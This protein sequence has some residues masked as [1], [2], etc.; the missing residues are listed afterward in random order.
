MSRG[1]LL[2]RRVRRKAAWWHTTMPDV[3]HGVPS[4]LG[5]CTGPYS[6]TPDPPQCQSLCDERCRLRS[7]APAEAIAAS[8]GTLSAQDGFAQ[9]SPD[10]RPRTMFANLT[11]RERKY[12][13]VPATELSAAPWGNRGQGPDGGSGG[14]STAVVR[15]AQMLAHAAHALLRPQT[16]STDPRHQRPARS[17]A[18]WT[19]TAATLRH[20]ARLPARLGRAKL[21]CLAVRLRAG[22]RLAPQARAPSAAPSL[23]AW[24]RRVSLP[25]PVPARPATAEAV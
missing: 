1:E 10:L 4:Q 14:L 22:T 15:C 21:H 5:T 24:P 16:S 12:E 8:K 25:G 17:C 18:R 9:S 6:P 7:G 20:A 13:R 11:G 3:R 2:V 19:R 23:R